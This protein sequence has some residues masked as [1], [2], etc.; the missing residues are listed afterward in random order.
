MNKNESRKIYRILTGRPEENFD[1][2]I[3]RVKE[4][5]ETS[6]IKFLDHFREAAKMV[7]LGSG[8]LF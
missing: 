5:Y 7:M 2:V 1:N 8:A 6:E 3:E 4:T